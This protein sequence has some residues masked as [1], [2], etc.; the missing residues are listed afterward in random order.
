MDSGGFILS[1]ENSTFILNNCY[2]DNVSSPITGNIF[3]IRLNNT[4]IVEN[5]TICTITETFF[6]GIAMAWFKN[7]LSFHNI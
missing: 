1:T 5:I 7:Y 6:S 4:L 3:N 2:F